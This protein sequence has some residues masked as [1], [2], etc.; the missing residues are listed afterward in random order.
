MAG[1]LA[2][3]W[4]ALCC[5]ANADPHQHLPLVATN[6]LSLFHLAKTA[7]HRITGDCC[8]GDTE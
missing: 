8:A 1:E 4:E 2:N 6:L 7:S 3:R 5:I